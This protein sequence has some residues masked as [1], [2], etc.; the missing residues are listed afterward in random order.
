MKDTMQADFKQSSESLMVKF[1]K[2]IDSI[3][4]KAK[5]DEAAQKAELNKLAQQYESETAK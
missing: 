1:Q 3:E 5:K 2:T 4:Q